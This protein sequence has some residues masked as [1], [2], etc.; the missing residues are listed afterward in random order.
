[1]AVTHNFFTSLTVAAIS[2]ISAPNIANA[3]QLTTNTYSLDFTTSDQSIWGTDNPF[4]F[5]DTRSISIPLRRESAITVGGTC[6]IPN[7]SGGCAVRAPSASAGLRTTGRFTF[8]NTV[9]INEGFVDAFIPINVNLTIPDSSEALEP[10][11]TFVIGSSFS[12]G[13]NAS[14][15]TSSPNVTDTLSL[16]FNLQAAA[17]ARATGLGEV[18]QTLF[19]QSIREDITVD[20][21]QLEYEI[22]SSYGR[23]LLEVP[24]INTTGTLVNSQTLVSS[25][26][27]RVLNAAIN[28]PNLALQLAG[29]PPVLS[30]T[31]GPRDSFRYDLLSLFL[32]GNINLSQNFSLIPDLSGTLILEND[33]TIPFTLGQDVSIT[34]PDDVGSS[35]DIDAV[36]DL[37]ALFRNQTGLSYGLGFDIILGRIRGPLGLSLGPLFQDER[38]LVSL[39]GFNVYDEAFELE[40]FNEQRISFEVSTQSIPEPNSAAALFGISLVSLRFMP[41]RKQQ[42]KS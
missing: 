13:N 32:G 15:T 35:L 7:L 9:N 28:L 10:G 4:N 41:R 6:I 5:T 18:R 3:I 31:F 11:E 17:F 14:F 24:E 22:N 16:I 38:E 42:K 21:E 34:I 37:N 30:G 23:L 20:N 27:D 25:G 12:L 8:Q 19:N 40:G 26:R 1:M 29:L 36:F 33:T 39:P 2:A